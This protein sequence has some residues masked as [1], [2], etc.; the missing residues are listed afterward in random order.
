MSEDAEATARAGDT[1]IA[2]RNGR[3]VTWS[4][5]LSD[6]QGVA[7]AL[8][9]HAHVINVCED[10]YLFLVGFTA[11]LARRQVSLLPPSRVTGVVV[12][13]AAEYPD[14]YL[15]VDGH[16]ADG[17]L[18]QFRIAVPPEPAA[19][20]VEDNDLLKDIDPDHLAAILFTSGST[21]RAMP[22][23]KSW[24]ALQRAAAASA[25]A[26]LPAGPRS[27][28]VATV[29]SQ[30]M[31]GFETTILWPLL[32]F[33][34]VHCDRPLFSEDVRSTLDSTPESR[35]LV[36]T[37]VHLR[38]MAEFPGDMPRLSAIICA[39]AP[40][41]PSLA[42]SSEA[43]FAA[44]LNEVFGST[45]TGITAVRRTTRDEP[46]RL[47]DPFTFDAGA[48][49]TTIRGRHLPAAVQLQDIVE[50]VDD[51]RFHLVGR[52]TDLINIAGK[53]ASLGD[54]N[55]RLLSIDGVQDGVIFMPDREPGS[56]AHKLV[57]RTAAFVVAP[58]LSREQVLAALR[59]L[60]DPAFLPRPLLMVDAL[61]RNEASKLPRADVLRMYAEQVGAPG[62]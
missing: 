49:G 31:Y 44:P 18:P 52:G 54:L 60:I 1:I 45:E 4:R 33:C 23:A 41:S 35:L 16:I 29:P 24:G 6:V 19:P 62:A 34:V 61:P 11:S 39:T 15:L 26:L 10:R 47:L 59:Q 17:A 46:W 37:P 36:T 32:G 28:V 53:R 40:L 12:G 21:G 5:F 38:A 13:I 14:S 2:W 43:K 20:A 48:T 7:A 22:H 58:G 42:A 25:S 56:E 30:H 51:R 50:P 27:V 8:P 3:G 55:A 57:V 9:R